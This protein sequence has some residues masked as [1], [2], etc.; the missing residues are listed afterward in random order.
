[1]ERYIEA[2]PLGA[3]VEYFDDGQGYDVHRNSDAFPKDQEK[4]DW[5]G[6]I[7]GG[8][9][10]DAE[11]VLMVAV[12]STDDPCVGHANDGQ[13]KVQGNPYVAERLNRGNGAA[14]PLAVPRKGAL[15]FA[16]AVSY[17]H[18]RAHET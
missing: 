2:L 5:F 4:E 8:N 3:G 14:V 17:T 11:L 18:L 15:V 10:Q 16:Q 1:M 6:E 7:D 13:D 12:N 9:I